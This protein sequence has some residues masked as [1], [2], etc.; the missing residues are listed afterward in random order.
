MNIEFPPGMPEDVQEFYKR[1]V[2]RQQM[3][4]DEHHLRIKGFFSELSLDHLQT[5]SRILA[6]AQTEPTNAAYMEGMADAYIELR[7]NVCPGCGKNHGTEELEQLLARQAELDRLDEQKAHPLFGVSSSE[8]VERPQDFSDAWTPD[9]NRLDDCSSCHGDRCLKVCNHPDGSH[10]QFTREACP[11]PRVVPCP[12][13]RTPKW[14]TEE[15]LQPSPCHSVSQQAVL[16]PS[17][18]ENVVLCSYCGTEHPY[19]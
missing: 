14:Y 9:G 6:R 5:F 17:F 13:C 1:Q 12:E 11:D 15:E 19:K 16:L 3:Q 18:E 7:F 8:I 2:E 4:N 10:G